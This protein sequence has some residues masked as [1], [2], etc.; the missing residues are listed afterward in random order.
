MKKMRLGLGIGEI[1][2]NPVNVDGLLD[3]VVAAERDGF[4]SAWFAN[5]FGM[6]AITACALAG[7]VTKRIE[8]GTAVV[9][10]F[11]RHPVAMAQQALSANAACG[12]R[13][14]LGIGLSHQLVIEGMFGLSFAKPFS[15]IREY[16]AVLAPLM[17]DGSV[18]FQGEEYRVQAQMAVTGATAPPILIAALAPRMLGLA[19]AQ[20]AGTVTWMTGPKTLREHTVPRLTEAAAKAGRPAPRVVCGLPIAVCDDPAVARERA[21]QAFSVYG[22]LP[23]YRSMLDKE[24]AAGPADVA[25]VGD[26]SAVGEQLERLADA[27][28]TD[29]LAAIFPVGGDAAASIART[30]ELLVKLAR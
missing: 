26:E 9:P 4:A 15:H 3:Q 20:A 17:R 22:M 7:R 13:F 6:D 2:G 11:P 28:V 10:T 23:S 29:F 8:L 18:S 25:I 12:G 19:G 24:G 5:I 1:A 14:T 16:M 21:A 27:G 30:R